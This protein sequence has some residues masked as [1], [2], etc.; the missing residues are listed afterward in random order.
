MPAGP[1]AHPQPHVCSLEEA[2]GPQG[3]HSE[4]SSRCP[5]LFLLKNKSSIYTGNCKLRLLAFLVLDFIEVRPQLTCLLSPDH[6]V[7]TE[8]GAGRGAGVHSLASSEGALAPALRE[9]AGGQSARRPPC[10][11][12]CPGTEG[13]GGCV[14]AASVRE[15]A[16]CCGGHLPCLSPA[17]GNQSPRHVAAQDRLRGSEP[18]PAVSG[19]SRQHLVCPLAAIKES[20]GQGSHPTAVWGKHQ[21]PT[22][23]VVGRTQLFRGCLKG[24]PPCLAGSSPPCP[25]AS[26]ARLPASPKPA[27]DKAQSVRPP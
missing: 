22:H 24:G 1:E 15:P 11:A 6:T 21:L 7:G 20:P 19:P 8:R 23:A 10:C 27:R 5:L 26:P 25:W 14:V 2:H 17:A 3:G 9:P 16:P 13:K 12:G 4:E 18:H